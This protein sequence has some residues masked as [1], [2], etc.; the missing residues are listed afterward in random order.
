MGDFNFSSNDVP[1]EIFVQAYNLTSLIKGVTYF[2]SSNMY[3]LCNTFE[4]R[5]SDHN[6]LISTVARKKL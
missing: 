1:L 3:K 6:K 5:L 4:T 2:Q